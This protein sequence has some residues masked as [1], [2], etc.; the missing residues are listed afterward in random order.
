MLS[1]WEAVPKSAVQEKKI[2]VN[3]LP[4]AG[5]EPAGVAATPVKQ[6]HLTNGVSCHHQDP[7]YFR[8]ITC[9]P[10]LHR[11]SRRLPQPTTPLPTSTGPPA[12]A[13][14]PPKLQA[15]SAT[16]PMSLRP[17]PSLPRSSRRDSVNARKFLSPTKSQ[18]CPPLRMR[19]GR[20]APRAYLSNTLRYCV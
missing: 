1:K 4:A 12:A 18:A 8:S 9:L 13:P 14:H 11:P 3:F 20:K 15:M 2:R 17:S 5:S 7:L 10:T 6:A 16:I 19:S